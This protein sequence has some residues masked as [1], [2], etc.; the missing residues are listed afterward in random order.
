[1]KKITFETKVPVGTRHIFSS[2]SS[3]SSLLVC[4]NKI[5]N[6]ITVAG[7]SRIFIIRFGNLPT[8]SYRMLYIKKLVFLLLPIYKYPVY[9]YLNTIYIW[10]FICLSV[11]LSVCTLL[12]QEPLNQFTWNRCQNN[13]KK[14]ACDIGQSFA[15]QVSY[16]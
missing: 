12:T 8:L 5:K 9:I 4:R 10:K 2:A 16:F 1:M 6:D 13:E 15:T 7:K 11:C 14:P 3:Y